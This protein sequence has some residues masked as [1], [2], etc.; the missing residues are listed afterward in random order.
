ME[1][2]LVTGTGYCQYT[3]KFEINSVDAYIDEFGYSW[4]HNPEDAPEYGCGNMKFEPKRASSELLAKYKITI[5]EFYEICDLID[6]KV[7]W[8]RCAMCS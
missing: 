1:V 8:G 5:E 4:D 6:S 7:S 3:E 2:T